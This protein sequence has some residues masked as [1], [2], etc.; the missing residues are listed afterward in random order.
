MISFV[1]HFRFWE[2]GFSFNNSEVRRSIT[3][4][5]YALI[6]QCNENSTVKVMIT[7]GTAST[8]TT[9]TGP[10]TINTVFTMRLSPRRHYAPFKDVECRLVYNRV[11]G[12]ITAEHCSG[13]LMRDLIL[14]QIEINAKLR[15]RINMDKGGHTL[16]PNLAENLPIST[17]NYINEIIKTSVYNLLDAALRKS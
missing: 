17:I 16:P 12:E 5:L 11:V 1:I 7:N 10:F 4:N 9:I 15:L 13:Y 8:A 14:G 6:R 2:W 3:V